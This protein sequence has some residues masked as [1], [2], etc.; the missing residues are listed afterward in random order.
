[1]T[2]IDRLVQ[3][4]RIMCV[5]CPFPGRICGAGDTCEDCWYKDEN[6]EEVEE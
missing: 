4:I 3:N 6:D 5:S 1:M 2:K